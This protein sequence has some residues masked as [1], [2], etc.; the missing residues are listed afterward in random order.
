MNILSSVIDKIELFDDQRE[1]TL[2]LVNENVQE[3]DDHT[4]GT[5]IEMFHTLSN[6]SSD[7]KLKWL[8][9]ALRS[10]AYY[11]EKPPI[12]R[13]N[14]GEDFSVAIDLEE[15]R[16]F[17]GFVLTIRKADDNSLL[18]PA[19]TAGD[20]YANA[21]TQYAYI[22]DLSLQADDF[23]KVHVLLEETDG[24]G[25]ASGDAV[26]LLTNAWLLVGEDIG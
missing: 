12:F 14:R 4:R 3:A 1:I 23:F 18:S 8:K 15:G 11:N 7:T 25:S 22:N 19:S 6:A 13:V 21:P 24:G 10:I 2:L 17:T 20:S 16:D 26:T 9:D 5:L